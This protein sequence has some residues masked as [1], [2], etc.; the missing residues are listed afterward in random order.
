MKTLFKVIGVILLLCIALIV[1][2][3][4]LI[5]TDTIF[6][7]VSEQ[8]EKTTGRT[9]TIKGDKTLSVF[10]ALKLE[11]NDVHFANMSSGSRADMASMQ[12]L[13][14]HIPWLSLL[15]GELKLEKFVINEPDILLETDKS[16]KANWQLFDA[17]AKQPE[18]QTQSGEAVKL[19]E[20]FDIQL[21]EVAIYG[22]SFTYLDGQTGAKQQISDLELAILLPSLRKQLE[23][24]GAITY[25]QERFELDVKLDTPAKAIEG[26]PF[27][28]KQTLNSRLVDLTFDGSIAKQGQDIKGLLALNGDSVKNI[29]NWQGVDLNAK[30]NAFNAFSINTQMHLLS[31]EFNLTELV[32][33]LDALEIK[34][35]SKVNLGSRLAVNADIDL[36]MLDL[37]PYLPETVAKKEAPVK[38][39]S[40]P[41]EPIVWDDTKIDLS[42]LS[43]LDANVIVRSSGLKA[44]DIKLGA[45]QFTMALKNSI[46][47]LSLDSFA[48]YE[49]TGKGVVTINAQNT[50][51]KIATNFDLDKIDAQP[52]LSDAAGFDKLMGK[53]SLSWNLTTAGQS[54][55]TFI[56]ALN[57][58]LG[59][60]FADG[61]VKG[62]NVAE[63]VRKG[64]ELVKGNFNAV[65]EGL[66][67]GFEESEKT[68][69][70]ALSGSF[71]FTNGVGK[72]TD[73]SLISP[74]IRISGEGD[75]DLPQTLVN[76]RLVTGVVDS[77]EGQ[78]TTD[79]STGFKVPLRIKGPFH[80]VNIKLDVSN[81]LKD[82][83]KQKLDDAKDKAKDKI[84]DKLKGLFG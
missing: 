32:A 47:K 11:L 8:V 69:F 3:P 75:V 76:Y 48:A 80:D 60:K 21:G 66:D 74:L 12:Q 6:N 70:S 34:G 33:T 49:G 65:S 37:N 81:A 19:P 64:K 79:D 36:G 61:A 16:G 46:A 53:G 39:E 51:Y 82:E 28:V 22:G 50:P 84:K 4:F 10:P 62:A 9:L 45:N 67:T 44:N 41:A 40:K 20:N 25:M 78:G 7:K 23:V 58:K 59:F 77:I 29:A 83:A 27:N 73:L 2:A 54:Q 17:V 68:D 56:N 26:A 13:A 71:N 63:M 55:K 72:N 14:V 18:Q 1:A 15:G 31:E 30:D 52:L 38:D 43:A 24:K 5:P 57:G 35:K 42:G